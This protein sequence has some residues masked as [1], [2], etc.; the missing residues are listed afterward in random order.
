[1]KIQRFSPKTPTEVV[2]LEFDFSKLCSSISG[3]TFSVAQVEPDAADPG[4]ANILEGNPTVIGGKVQ[5]RV[6]AGLAGYD[7]Q[8]LCQVM[9]N[10]GFG[11]TFELSGQLSV[12]N[13]RE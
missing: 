7:Y 1:M 12:R 3:T 8:I 9:T 10:E 13:P 5:Q 6:K 2:L 4:I 11:Q